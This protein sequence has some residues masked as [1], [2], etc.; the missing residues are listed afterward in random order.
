M[1]ISYIL[2]PIREEKIVTKKHPIDVESIYNKHIEK[3][4]SQ[5]KKKIDLERFVGLPEN[6]Y[7]SSSSGMCSRKIYYESIEKAEK[8]EEIDDKTRRLF[9]LG[10]IVHEDMQEALLNHDKD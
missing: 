4:S 3:K 1:R 8:T 9:R 6:T 7:R 5:Q 10:T 2:I